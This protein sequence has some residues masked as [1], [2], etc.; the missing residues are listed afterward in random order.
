[1]KTIEQMRKAYEPRLRELHAEMESTIFAPESTWQQ[2]IN[3][4]SELLDTIGCE[5][6]AVQYATLCRP[7]YSP[8]EAFRQKDV[9]AQR[10]GYMFIPLSKEEHE[11]VLKEWEKWNENPMLKEVEKRRRETLNDPAMTAELERWASDFAKLSVP[12]FDKHI[13]ASHV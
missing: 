11:R 12:K 2:L 9:T 10:Y 6:Y 3:S 7:S 13:Q 5:G 1:M 4:L 8:M